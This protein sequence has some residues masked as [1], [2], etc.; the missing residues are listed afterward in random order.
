MCH[1]SHCSCLWVIDWSL[2]LSWEWRCSW[3][4]ADRRCSNYICVI[5]NCAAYQGATYIRDLTVIWT[6]WTFLDLI[7]QNGVIKH[8]RIMTFGYLISHRPHKFPGTGV[9]HPLMT[10]A[11]IKWLRNTTRPSETSWCYSTPQVT[12]NIVTKH[13]GLDAGQHVQVNV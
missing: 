10:A 8:D 9:R 6:S 11:C 7:I 4:S 13:S 2:V 5:N 12:G 3:S 1:A